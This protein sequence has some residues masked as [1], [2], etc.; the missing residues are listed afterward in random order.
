MPVM[1]SRNR[2]AF[3]M[4]ELLAV[5]MII[6]VLIALLLPAQAA[7]REAA[8]RAQ[9]I[10]NLKQIGLACHSYHDQYGALPTG[11]SVTFDS[12]YAG[13]NK[14]G[15]GDNQ[16]WMVR[17]LPF[18][19]ETN[20]YNA[21]NH[22]TWIS[23]AENFTSISGVVGHYACPSEPRSKRTWRIDS[24]DL[25][26][27]GF[28]VGRR[29]PYVMPSSYA[30]I[31]GTTTLRIKY[32]MDDNCNIPRPI[33]EALNGV[34]SWEP[35]R[36]Q[37]ITDGLSSTLLAGDR[38]TTQWPESKTRLVKGEWYLAGFRHSLATTMLPP[39]FF[40]NQKIANKNQPVSEHYASS[41]NS[42][43]TMMVNALLCDGSVR[44]VRSN[45]Q[46]RPVNTSRLL[47]E[48]SKIDAETGIYRNLP[49]AGV[50][51][52]LS[53]RSGG[54]V[55][56]EDDYDSTAHFKEMKPDADPN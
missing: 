2:P 14:C 30:A 49:K 36:F 52:A 45:I 5:I 39:N 11:F 18:L 53:T 51:Q 35:I 43:H 25:K 4:I 44:V 26:S 46:S 22:Q 15:G 33:L 7:S 17:I 41:L 48:G 24:T 21:L 37:D 9:C 55:I 13:L 27:L 42:F 34:M 40:Q 56:I 28:P 32:N 20:R 6:A 19:E 31:A 23:S 10:N 38:A 54:E 16:S 3:T 29:T 1:N 12:R 47:P 8:R 50:W